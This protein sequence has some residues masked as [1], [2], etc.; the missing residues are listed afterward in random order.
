MQFKSINELGP[1]SAKGK[2][3]KMKSVRLMENLSDNTK[4]IKLPAGAIGYC[5]SCTMGS[6]FLAFEKEMLQVPR[7][8]MSGTNYPIAVQFTFRETYYSLEIES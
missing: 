8:R 7:I 6:M 4:R 2:M 5:Y 3:F 1:S